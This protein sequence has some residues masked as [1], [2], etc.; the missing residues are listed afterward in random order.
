MYHVNGSALK[1]SYSRNKLGAYHR[2][3]GLNRALNFILGKLLHNRIKGFIYL[4]FNR[5]SCRRSV[6]YRNAKSK[7]FILHPCQ[8]NLRK[9][10]SVASHKLLVA[11]KH[12]IIRTDSCLY[13]ALCD[14]AY[15]T[16]T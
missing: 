12:R 6:I 16:F 3:I 5:Y 1:G 4:I 10:N 15:L 7:Y 8:N 2:V 11:Y 14:S 13:S 9:G